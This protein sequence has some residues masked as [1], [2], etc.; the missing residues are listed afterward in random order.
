[1]LK[2]QQHDLKPRSNFES[3]VAKVMVL[4]LVNFVSRSDTIIQVESLLNAVLAG[5]FLS[6]VLY[7]P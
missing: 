6:P 1:M 2:G 5:L 4:N 7:P 3:L